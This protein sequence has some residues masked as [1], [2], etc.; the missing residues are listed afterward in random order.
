MEITVIFSFSKDALTQ[1]INTEYLSILLQ[2]MW[3][4]SHVHIYITYFSV[5]RN[6][7]N[8][9]NKAQI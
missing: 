7:V 8:C 5:Q 9:N 2:S 6:N 3:Y 4:N 1:N